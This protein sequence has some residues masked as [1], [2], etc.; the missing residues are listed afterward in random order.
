MQCEPGAGAR[1]L[2]FGAAASAYERFRPGY[3][4]QLVDTVLAY[5]DQPI[6]SALEIGAGTGKATRIFAE[7]GIGAATIEP[8]S[9][10]DATKNGFSSSPPLPRANRR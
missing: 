5:S 4:A 7:R 10:P 6:R 2:S 9:T 3:P 1:A 8:G